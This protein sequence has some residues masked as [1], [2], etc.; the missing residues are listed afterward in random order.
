MLKNVIPTDEIEKQL[1]QKINIKEYGFESINQ[2]A[3]LTP[4]TCRQI[5]LTVWDKIVEMGKHSVDPMAISNYVQSGEPKLHMKI[6]NIIGKKIIN[7]I[8]YATG[9]ISGGFDDNQVFEI[10]LS[11]VY[12]NDLYLADIFIKNPN[13]PI[14]ESERKSIL[15]THRGFGL[16]DIVMKNI[17]L[18]ATELECERISLTASFLEQVDLFKKYGFQVR[19]SPA[20]KAAMEYG[21]GIPMEKNI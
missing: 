4:T 6:E 14:K 17:D 8:Y 15:Q 12:P 21:M 18:L 9:E 11:H 10:L 1:D 13:Y 7:D 2:I 3:E 16:L 20:G 19:N 5:G